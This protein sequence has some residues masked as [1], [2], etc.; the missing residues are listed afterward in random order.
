MKQALKFQA[1]QKMLAKCPFC[2]SDQGKYT[3]SSVGTNQ[4][5]ELVFIRCQACQTAMVTLLVSAGSMVSSIGL[6]TDLTVED[7]DRLS[8]NQTISADEVMDWH[9]QLKSTNIVSDLHKL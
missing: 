7:M 6:L 5:A 4:S 2:K 3:T 9:N 1:L 8:N